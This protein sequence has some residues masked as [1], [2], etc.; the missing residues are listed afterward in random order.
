M[1]L[2]PTRETKNVETLVDVALS[3]LEI[4]PLSPNSDISHYR[5]F[6]VEIGLVQP[7]FDRHFGTYQSLRIHSLR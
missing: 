2:Y 7:F 4:A 1:E 5:T 3:P 6:R